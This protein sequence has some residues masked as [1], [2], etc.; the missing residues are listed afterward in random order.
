MNVLLSN[1]VVGRNDDYGGGYLDRLATSLNHLAENL[2]K[3]DR[4]RD[5]EVVYVDWGSDVPV[6]EAVKLTPDAARI[7]RFVEVGREV[8]AGLGEPGS[9]Y[10]TLAVNVGVR[11]A[12]GAYVM[13]ADSD[14]LMRRSA[15]SSLLKLLD[16]SLDPGFDPTRCI[17]PIRR[18]QIPYDIVRRKPSLRR[19][20]ELLGGLQPGARVESPG[21]GCLGGFSA[22]QLMHRRLWEEFRGYNESLKRPWGWSDNELMLRV[23]AKYDWADLVAYGVM[24]FHMEHGPRRRWWD[25]TDLPKRDASKVN[26][27]LVAADAAPNGPDW[28]LADRDLRVRRA[29][30]S[31]SGDLRD[32]R[33]PDVAPL[34]HELTH[35]ASIKAA[36]MAP[37]VRDSMQRVLKHC[38]RAYGVHPDKGDEQCLALLI[39]FVSAASPLNFVHCGSLAMHLLFGVLSEHTAIQTYL[40]RPWDDGDASAQPCHPG[41]L[42]QILEHSMYRGYAR[43]MGGDPTAALASLPLPGGIEFALVHTAQREGHTAAI[44]QGTV[45]RLARG[46]A[47]VVHGPQDSREMERYDR[48]ASDGIRSALDPERPYDTARRPFSRSLWQH[49]VMRVVTVIPNRLTYLVRQPAISGS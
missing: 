49:D 27:M 19:W 18:I 8:V 2:R 41:V 26:R 46:G 29:T 12:L 32:A 39:S 40:L 22:G 16:G 4:Q 28:G 5:V 30:P 45:A 17:L 14:G 38:G 10:A 33:G 21:T 35:G 11:R 25:A 43:I 3:E 44:V 15:L 6:A 34:L 9:F 13:L 20:D 48:V 24:A 1:V 37:Y 23:T 7:V 42:S 47:L 36:V 31:H